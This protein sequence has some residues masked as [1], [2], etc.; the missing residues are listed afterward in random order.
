M[1][2]IVRIA[3]NNITPGGTKKK[4][5]FINDD[6]DIKNLCAI[7]TKLRQWQKGTV[8]PS[9]PNVGDKWEDSSTTPSVLK[10]WDGSA[11]V[12][13]DVFVSGGDV[14]ITATPNKILRL[15]NDGELPTNAD[16]ANKLKTAIDI[17]DVSFDGSSDIYIPVG[18]QGLYKNLKIQVISDTQAT[19]TADQIILFDSLNNSKFISGLSTTLDKTILGANGLDT[20]VI[21]NSA[22]YYVFAIA[23]ADGTKGVLMSLSPTSPTMPTDYTYKARIGAIRTHSDGTLIRTLQYGCVAQYVVNPSTNTTSRAI[24]TGTHGNM[25]MPTWTPASITE[26]V[27]ST[28]RK[29]G[30]VLYAVGSPPAAMAAPNQNYWSYNNPVNPPPLMIYNNT[31]ANH[32]IK[33]EFVIES[34]NIYYAGTTSDCGLICSG[35]EDNL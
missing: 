26:F 9:S 3:P 31:A 25:S 19:I 15:N 6:L 14:V 2:D 35:W 30:L 27:P 33:G 10:E 12:A 7:A 16:S 5:G 13:V 32:V 34:S 11:W 18:V 21:T 4:Q 29:I 22:W 23:K 8:A 24:I 1:A 20:G 17:N 28:A